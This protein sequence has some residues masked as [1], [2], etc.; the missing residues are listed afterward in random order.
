MIILFVIFMLFIFVGYH[1]SKYLQRE[2][3][4]ERQKRSSSEEERDSV[5]SEK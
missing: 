5:S 3:D 2:K 1:N 4:E